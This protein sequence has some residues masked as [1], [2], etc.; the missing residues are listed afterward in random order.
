MDLK[1]QGKFVVVTGSTQG[2]GKAV[3][4]KFIELGSKVVI[5]GRSEKTVT[6]V[7][8]ELNSLQKG[9]AIGIAADLTN[10]EGA[11]SFME[12]IKS[13]GHVDVLVNNLGIFE[14]KSFEQ[15]TDEEWL[16]YF[17]VNVVSAVRLCRVYLPQMLQRNSGAIIIVSSDA[18]VMPKPF[19]I[20]YSVTKTAQL[21][22]ARGLA[23]L[24]KGTRVRVNSV[25]PGPTW[26]EGVQ[27]YIQGLASQKNEDVEITKK[28]YFNQTEPTSLIQ[29]FIDPEEVANVVAFLSSEVSSC[30]TGVSQHSEGGIIR[31][32]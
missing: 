14:A 13:H 22:L 15:I 24:T 9:E 28:D 11:D 10:K 31:H 26:T 5:N 29:R 21:G 20:H 1:L 27:T 19:M 4:K 17:N 12:R 2:I 7:V 6:Q 3:A 25:L 32:I 18:A 30:V 23:E 8:E 16:N